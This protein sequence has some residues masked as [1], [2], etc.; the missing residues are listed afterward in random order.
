MQYRNIYSIYDILIILIVNYYCKYINTPHTVTDTHDRPDAARGAARRTPVSHT[1]NRDA[2][3]C[4]YI[5]SPV[6]HTQERLRRLRSSATHQVAE[7]ERIAHHPADAAAVPESASEVVDNLV[8]VE[9]SARSSLDFML[10][11]IVKAMRPASVKKKM[12]RN[13]GGRFSKGT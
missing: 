6:D 8:G 9:G 3:A 2:H 10:Q 1:S 13:I 4:V 5:F 7:R 11:L 12:T